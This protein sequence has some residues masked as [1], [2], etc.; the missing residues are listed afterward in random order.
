MSFPFGRTVSIWEPIKGYRPLP[1]PPPCILDWCGIAGKSNEMWQSKNICTCSYTMMSSPKFE[2]VWWK[3]ERCAAKCCPR[4][5][6]RCFKWAA[7]VNVEN[8]AHFWN[9]D[10]VLCTMYYVPSTLYYRAPWGTHHEAPCGTMAPTKKMKTYISIISRRAS[11]G[12]CQTKWL[13]LQ[14]TQKKNRR[15]VRSANNSNIIPV[16]FRTLPVT[17]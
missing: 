10:H 2:F 13:G 4:A 7:L 15:P 9:V 6:C 1:R 5:I 3:L 16:R 11:L 17:K 8:D 14:G 12:I